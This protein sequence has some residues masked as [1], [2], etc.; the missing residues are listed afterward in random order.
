VCQAC[1]TDLLDGARHLY[2]DEGDTRTRDGSLSRREALKLGVG[3]ATLVALS[4]LLPATRAAAAQRA[5]IGARGPSA[6]SGAVP[7]SMAMH[8]HSSFSEREGSME[9]ALSEAAANSV[10][11]LWWTEHDWR[12]AHTCYRTQVSFD[13]LTG[14]LQFGEPWTWRPSTSGAPSATGGGIVSTPVSPGDPSPAGALEVSVQ[15]VAGSDAA[16]G[17]WADTNLSR[18]NHSGNID[19]LGFAIDVYP[20][21]VRGGGFLEVLVSLSRHPSSVAGLDG[22]YTITYRF[23]PTGNSTIGGN[24]PGSYVTRGRVGI[25]TQALPPTTYTSVALDLVADAARLWPHIDGRDNS[26][27]Q[28][29]LRAGSVGPGSALGYFDNL[30]FAWPS[31][32]ATQATQAALMTEYAP[33][34]PTVQQFATQEIS[35]HENEHFNVFGG[36]V[37]IDTNAGATVLYPPS[38]TVAWFEALTAANRAAGALTS[39][40]HVY[41]TSAN[42]LLNANAAAALQASTI[43]MLIQTGAFGVDVFEAG[44][45]ARGGMDLEAHLAAWDA[46][47]RNG[48]VMTANG[49]NDDHHGAHGSW[50]TEPN[51]FITVAWAAGLAESDLLTALAT[52]RVF[53]T[54]LS[55]FTGTLDLQLDD[56]TPMGGIAARGTVST[57]QLTVLAAGLPASGYLELVR[58]VVDFAGVTVPEPGTT[59]VATIPATALTRGNTTVGVDTSVDCF[60][61]LNLVDPTMPTSS[62]RIAFSNPIWIVNAALTG[63]TAGR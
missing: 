12:M 61:R 54:A 22:T 4:S 63:A 18:G 24:P 55:T 44:Y 45:R 37:P 26:L 34:F 19:G 42:N 1:D 16:Y 20:G 33:R 51:R 52:G 9:S 8:V 53:V 7:V 47:S 2:G 6:T 27:V 35:Y 38:A 5:G 13:S 31:V 43:V 30:R 28:L 25:V 3:T 10:D 46:C 62:Q 39:L 32:G 57:R 14:E 29:H 23:G 48:I 41:G 59:V 36:A 17:F 21:T 50:G 11:V 56:G 58:G 49:T 15:Q 60:Y 40:N